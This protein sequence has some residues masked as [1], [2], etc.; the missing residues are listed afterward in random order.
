[1][2]DI[3]CLDSAGKRNLGVLTFAAAPRVGEI[4]MTDTG[5][6]LVKTIEHAPVATGSGS[7]PIVT[8]YLE[9]R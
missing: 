6:Y 8:A 7:A 9:A 1:M 5:E 2:V 3:M 4:V